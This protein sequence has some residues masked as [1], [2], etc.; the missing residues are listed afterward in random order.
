M[1]KDSNQNN[2]SYPVDR[3]LDYPKGHFVEPKIES[4]EK[5]LAKV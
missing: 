1:D 2:I 3:V 4:V 5:H